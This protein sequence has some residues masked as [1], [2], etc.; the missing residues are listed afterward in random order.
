MAVIKYG[1]EGNYELITA[2]NISLET[3]LGVLPIV[4]GGTGKTTAAEALSALGAVSK[5]GDT[6][7]GDLTVDNLTV[8]GY[9]N[10][11][12]GISSFCGMTAYM[13]SNLGSIN[14][15]GDA[16]IQLDTVM[17]SYG[18]ISLSSY[19]INI[20]V[21]GHYYVEGQIMFNDG[22]ANKYMGITI[23]QNGS[24]I[25]DAYAGSPVNYGCVSTAGSVRKF[26]AGDKITLFA[27]TPSSGITI[28][29]NTRTKLTVFRLF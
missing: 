18:N 3:G 14:T 26:N 4:K 13:S 22:I 8:N 15:T 16:Q 24:V 28:N 12:Q 5:T 1:S 27:R 2:T 29:G 10:S 25:S 9:I 7:D 17:D 19:A 23:K 20:S 6:I 11:N 21:T